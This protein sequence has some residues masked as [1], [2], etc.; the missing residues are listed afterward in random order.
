MLMGAKHKVLIF[1]DHANLQYYCQP[2]KI[3]WCVARYIS[4]LAEYHYKLIHKPGKYNK[5]NLLSCRPDY[6]QGKDDN[7][8]ITMLPDSLFVCTISLS[9]LEDMVFST[10][11]Y[12]KPTL[13]A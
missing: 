1:M 4:C 6:D 11:G 10:Q 12:A 2:H 3:N 7:S 13:L 9:L 5:A 8:D